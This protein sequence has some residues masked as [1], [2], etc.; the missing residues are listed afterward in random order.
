[1]L[2]LLIPGAGAA[3]LAFLQR[4]LIRCG[5]ARTPMQAPKF[6]PTMSPPGTRQVIQ[7]PNNSLD[8]L[9]FDFLPP[10]I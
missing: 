5:L 9:L 10:I 1:M 2:D 4:A 8:S 3:I 6:P 7:P